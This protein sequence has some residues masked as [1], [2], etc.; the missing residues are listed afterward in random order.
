MRA[1]P[2]TARKPW[3]TV[4]DA[5][6][7]I[8]PEDIAADAAEPAITEP[9]ASGAAGPDAEEVMVTDA[10]GFVEPEEAP[11]VDD[12]PDPDVPQPEE[13]APDMAGAEDDAA[14]YEAAE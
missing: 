11:A 12:V 5:P 10:A 2:H 3:K 9:E 14:F 13:I 1:R 7:T 4:A 8:E 6:G